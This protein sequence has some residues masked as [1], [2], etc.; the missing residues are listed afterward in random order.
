MWRRHGF[1]LIELLVV[2]AIIAILASLLLVAVQRAR[3]A[4]D[5]ITCINNLHQIGLAALLYNNSNGALPWVRLCPDL[6]NDPHCFTVTRSEGSSTG[7]NEVWWAPYDN[8]PG[9][10][11][12]TIVNNDY[13]RG[14]LWPYVE[15]NRAI[16]N[17][18]EGFEIRRDNPNY[19]KR[20]QVSYGMNN[21][22]GGPAGQALLSITQGAG[23]SNVMF[24][25]DHAHTPD[26]SN[27]G[28]PRTPVTPF[29]DPQ[30][31]HYPQ[32]HNGIYNVLFCDGHVAPMRQ[33]ELN[34]ALFYIQ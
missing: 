34:T 14:M 15:Q 5:R 3:V 13:Q 12:T 1:T 30:T 23:T 24:V 20:L 6:P 29:I 25:W 7:P 16:F 32:R 4:A 27:D 26:C 21:I 19:G 9:S 18:P 2:I 28:Y 33:A 17:C 8:R 10:N 11:P 22:T 31:I